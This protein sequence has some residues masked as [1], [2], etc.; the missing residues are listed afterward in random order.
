MA[1]NMLVSID[2]AIICFSIT[3]AILIFIKKI[4]VG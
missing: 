4:N 1:L 3:M 2:S